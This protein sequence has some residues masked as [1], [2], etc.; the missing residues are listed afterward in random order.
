MVVSAAPGTGRFFL[1]AAFPS[2]GLLSGVSAY[3]FTD[4]MVMKGEA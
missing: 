4:R 2:R 1:T 3:S